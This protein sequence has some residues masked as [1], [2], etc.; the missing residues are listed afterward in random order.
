M[1]KLE[2]QP[3]EPPSAKKTPEE[4]KEPTAQ[5]LVTEIKTYINS[6]EFGTLFQS[7]NAQ[8]KISQNKKD[9]IDTTWRELKVEFNKLKNRSTGYVDTTE[10]PLIDDVKAYRTKFDQ[11]VKGLQEELRTAVMLQEQEEAEKM[12]Q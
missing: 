12:L 8:P 1:G 6:P 7:I 5:E 10:T 2:N 4:K 3:P 11:F 9:Q